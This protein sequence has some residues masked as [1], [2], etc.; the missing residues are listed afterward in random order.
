MIRAVPIK[1]IK[2]LLCRYTL[3]INLNF[4]NILLTPYRYIFYCDK[5]NTYTVRIYHLMPIHKCLH[6]E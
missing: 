3:L 4:L 6:T 5:V 2:Y 1:V